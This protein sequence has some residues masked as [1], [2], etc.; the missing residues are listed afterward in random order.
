M[1]NSPQPRRLNIPCKERARLGDVFA[2]IA[3]EYTQ[4]IVRTRPSEGGAFEGERNRISKVRIARELALNA[5]QEHEREHECGV[6]YR[7]ARESL[8]RTKA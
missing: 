8:Y 7:V 4:S 1:S 6:V 5:L 2:S 3:L